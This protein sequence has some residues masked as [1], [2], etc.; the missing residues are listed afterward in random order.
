MGGTVRLGDGGLLWH[1]HFSEA[2]GS[3]TLGRPP[4]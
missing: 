3:W 4:A 2:I 1:G